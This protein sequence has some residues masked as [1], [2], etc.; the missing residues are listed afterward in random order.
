MATATSTASIERELHIKARPEAVFALLTD[1]ARIPE[2]MGREAW[3][4]P[5]PGGVYRVDYN[6]F[7]I[8]S[9]K[10]LE[11]EPPSRFVVTWGWES[12]DAGMMKPGSSTLE[13]TLSAEGEGTKLRMVHSGL[14]GH[15]AASHAEGWD[16]FLPKLTSLA[17]GGRPERM[18]VELSPGPYLAGQLN[19]LLIEFVGLLEGYSAARW[20]TPVANDGRTGAE[21]A[22][23]ILDHLNVV[24]FAR[25]VARGERAPQSDFTVEALDAVNAARAKESSGVTAAELVAR[26]RQDGPKAVEALKG[27]TEA[28]MAMKQSMAFAGGAELP[29]AALVHGPLIE[30][31]KEHLATLRAHGA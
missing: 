19:T 25:T 2:W 29:A 26:A 8:V 23:H 18:P 10:V 31:I 13:F 3:V 24:E 6:G 20:R 17:T 5:R 28:D 22:A 4:E 21:V 9:G 30:N 16:M 27:M 11:C 15:D 12:L 14:H 7:D 1:P